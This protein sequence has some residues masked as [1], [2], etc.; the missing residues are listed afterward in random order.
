ME[1]PE[2][3]VI[4]DWYAKKEKLFSFFIFCL[5]VFLGE[6][7]L[8]YAG[9]KGYLGWINIAV[10]HSLLTFV[11]IAV[12][13][14]FVRLQYDLRLPLLFVILLAFLGPVGAGMMLIIIL[15]YAI[16]KR[17]LSDSGEGLLEVLYPDIQISKSTL[18]YNRIAYGM[19]D[20]EIKEGAASYRDIISFGSIPQ[21]RNALEKIG[22]YFRP[23][24]VPMLQMALND[25]NP[26]IRVYAGTI[27][28]QLETQ[29]YNHFLKL[30]HLVKAKPNNLR[31]L[32]A[33]AQHG[34]RYVNSKILAPDRVNK[35][36]TQTLEAYQRCL[37]YA[38]Y[39]R[40]ILLSLSSLYLNA[41]DY[42]KAIYYANQLISEHKIVPAKVYLNLMQ[43]YYIQKQYD[44]VRKIAQQTNI[45]GPEDPDAEELKELITL[46]KKD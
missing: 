23:E 35:I 10:I 1:L 39:D 22:R 18:I 25:P 16:E 46:W 14:A 11:S 2:I 7:L 38:P 45:L 15:L 36:R 26:S 32:L 21:K 37:K 6:I 31:Y 33:F 28:T 13:A 5:F 34:E 40:E 44:Y 8:L 43:A 42:E 27:F 24:F 30:E 17:F 12:L 19:E 4:L 29:F 20:T 41:H 9:L 3:D